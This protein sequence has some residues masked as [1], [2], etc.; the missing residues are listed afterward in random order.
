[1][2]CMASRKS[3]PSKQASSLSASPFLTSL[4]S[5]IAPTGW[6]GLKAHQGNSPNVMKVV[7]APSPT[8]E[9]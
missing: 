1:M 6:R 3:S 5:F 9:E 2:L 8:T 7:I 4:V